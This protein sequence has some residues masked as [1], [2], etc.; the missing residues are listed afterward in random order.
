MAV[1]LIYNKESNSSQAWLILMDTNR[2][3][4]VSY[5]LSISGNGSARADDVVANR[6]GTFTV[7]GYTFVQYNSYI[8]Y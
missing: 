6:D 4:H 5:T 8:F 7:V 2:V 3:S 1:G